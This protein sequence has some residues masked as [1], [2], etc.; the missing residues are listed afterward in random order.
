MMVGRQED[1][2]WGA[3]LTKPEYTKWNYETE[4]K[5]QELETINLQANLQEGQK[6][7]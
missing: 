4:K 7:Q 1:V 5:V 6:T 2:E 3:K